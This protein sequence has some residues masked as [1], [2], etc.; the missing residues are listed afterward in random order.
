MLAL[1]GVLLA[2]LHVEHELVFGVVHPFEGSHH[3]GQACNAAVVP[4]C[5]N[6]LDHIQRSVDLE[7]IRCDPLER[8][9]PVRF[10]DRE[11]QAD[12]EPEVR[13]A[14]EFFTASS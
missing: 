4:A 5:A 3:R 10:S 7:L 9:V 6:P 12:G 14:S 11:T 8:P 13:V 1:S 2:G